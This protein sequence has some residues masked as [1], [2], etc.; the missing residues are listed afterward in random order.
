MWEGLVEAAVIAEKGI[1]P[2]MEDAHYLDQDFGGK[3]W[4]YG[5]IYDGHNGGYAANHAA[6]RLHTIF[7]EQLAAESS[8]RE[9]FA[10]SYETVSRE[11]SGRESGTTAVDFLI[12][13]KKIIT[14][15]AGD[16]RAVIQQ[17]PDT[18]VGS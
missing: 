2:A 4:I 6:A 3:G 5:G 17:Y 7:W 16:A 18:P 8:P 12:R 1:R 11:V 9:A 14:A 13:D 15:N 10:L